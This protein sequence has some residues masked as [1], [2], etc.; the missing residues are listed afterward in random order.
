MLQICSLGIKYQKQ[1]EDRCFLLYYREKRSQLRTHFTDE[2]YL[3]FWLKLINVHIPNLKL[4]LKKVSV[5]FCCPLHHWIAHI[6][7]Q[8]KTE[9][10]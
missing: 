5:F 9:F 2:L 6:V 10:Y 8:C 1:L 4:L 3:I 7:V